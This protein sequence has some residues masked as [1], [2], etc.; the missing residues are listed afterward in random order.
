M[1]NHNHELNSGDKFGSWT[2]LHK[3]DKKLF[4]HILY[5]CRCE[6]GTEK[7]VIKQQLVNGTSKCCG[8]KKK[9]LSGLSSLPEYNVWL[10]MISRCSDPKN[11]GWNNYGGRGITVCPEWQGINGFKQ[12]LNDMG[13][14]P[15]GRYSIDRSNNDQGYN[16]LNCYWQ[17]S[18]HQ[19]SNK[20]SVDDLS[21]IPN[22]VLISEGKR[23]GL[24]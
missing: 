12:F 19:N 7:L 6:C 3:S 18:S 1:S 14:R 24:I 11:K 17:T 10:S 15:K 23:R 20:R 21:W 8:C 5:M 16:K 22:N 13:S 9:T 2:I 4:R